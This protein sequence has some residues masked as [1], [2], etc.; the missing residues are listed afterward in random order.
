MRA[1]S[2]PYRNYTFR[3]LITKRS[4]SCEVPSIRF[5]PFGRGSKNQKFSLLCLYRFP[6][7]RVPDYGIHPRHS[8]RT[9]PLWLRAPRCLGFLLILALPLCGAVARAG[10][11]LGE[12]RNPSPSFASSRQGSTNRLSQPPFSFSYQLYV[13]SLSLLDFC[14]ARLRRRSSFSHGRPSGNVRGS[15]SYCTL[16][17]LSRSR[18]RKTPLARTRGVRAGLPYLEF[19][20]LVKQTL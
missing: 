2:A 14:I 15:N 6:F 3:I 10:D 8:P 17:P 18:V 20:I 7:L 16:D 1:S 9:F 13:V 12:G 11:C 4:R 5:S 19:L